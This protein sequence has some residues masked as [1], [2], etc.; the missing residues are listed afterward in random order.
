MPIIM[1][2]FSL[3]FFTYSLYSYLLS[4]AFSFYFIALFAIYWP[5]DFSALSCALSSQ[6]DFGCPI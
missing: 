1:Q 4:L 2:H 6:T 5:D 3:I